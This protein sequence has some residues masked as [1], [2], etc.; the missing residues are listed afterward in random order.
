MICPNCGE[1][2]SQ[3]FRFCGMCG[4]PLTAPPPAPEAMSAPNHAMAAAPAA[5]HRAGERRSEPRVVPITLEV[6]PPPEKSESATISGP[7]LLGLDQSFSTKPASDAP[8]DRPFSPAHS[9]LE[10]EEPGTGGRRI[11]VLLALLVALGAAAW[12]TY[13]NYQGATSR[14][15]RAVAS[16]PAT[17][18]AAPATASAKP[19]TAAPANPQPG[20]SAVSPPAQAAPQKAA[21]AQAKSPS[22]PPAKQ[23]DASPKAGAQPAIRVTAARP[24]NAQAEVPPAPSKPVAAPPSGDS[25][26]ADYRKGEAY[27]YGRGVAEDCGQAVKYLKAASAKQ[28]AKARSAFGTMYA[29]GHCVPRDLPTSYGWFALALHADPNNQILEKDL[30]AVWNQMTPPERQMATKMKP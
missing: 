21:A 30:T 20:A 22:P 12:W 10:P 5:Q 15:S 24:K 27:L 17:P 3:A 19:E 29:T 25:G 23:Q 18:V 6:P 16:N 4:T 7:S 8:A 14:V 2:N 28:S 11:L 9:F 1:D 13:S 26:D